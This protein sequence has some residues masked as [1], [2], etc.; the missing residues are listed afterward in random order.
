MQTRNP[1]R[2][3]LS[4]MMTGVAGMAQ[5]AGDEMKALARSQGERLVADMD[6]AGRDEVEALK[7]LARTALEKVEAL[8]KRV[9]ELEG[10]RANRRPAP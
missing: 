3:D 1:L 9:A 5:A 2:D 10:G 6:L 4:R 7:T 8:E